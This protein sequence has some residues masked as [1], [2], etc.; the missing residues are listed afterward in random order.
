MRFLKNTWI[1]IRSY[2]KALIFIIEHKLYWYVALPAVLMLG[3][4]KVGHSILVSKPNYEATNMNEIGW[5]LIQLFFEL[6]ISIALMRFAKYLV[7]IVLSPLLSHLSQ[8]VEY[9]IT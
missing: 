8:K 5:L 1:G 9:K 7:V 3:I 4:Y 2:R 6:S